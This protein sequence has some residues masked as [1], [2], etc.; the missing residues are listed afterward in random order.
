MYVCVW[1]REQERE[2]EERKWK[3]CTHMP[4]AKQGF[5]QRASRP[6]LPRDVITG[7]FSQYC[8][9]FFFFLFPCLFCAYMPGEAVRKGN[10]QSEADCGCCGGRW[11]QPPT[12]T[13]NPNFPSRWLNLVLF[14]WKLVLYPIWCR[15]VQCALIVTHTRSYTYWWV[16]KNS[17]EGGNVCRWWWRGQ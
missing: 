10:P 6:F 4:P 12:Q 13:L 9:S 11:L 2:E 1:E 3:W 8:F 16:K 7:S 5:E 17:M 14:W 15:A